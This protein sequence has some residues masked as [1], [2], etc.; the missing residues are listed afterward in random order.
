MKT[1]PERLLTAASC[2]E[3]GSVIADVGCDHG[4]LPH[5]LL[6][7]GISV[8]AYLIDKNRGPLLRA[9]QNTE[10]Y[11]LSDSCAHVVSDG[12]KELNTF[13]SDNNV[14]AGIPDTVIMTG[15]GGPLILKIIDE[16]PEEIKRNVSTF[17]LSPQSL[18]EDCKEGL[19]ERG[20]M[21]RDEKM[22]SDKGKHY[23]IIKGE[24]N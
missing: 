13:I 7:K 21:I 10:K 15:M 4:L 22:V 11:G 8:F 9:A 23:T 20:F 14:P 17:I 16:A 3:K 18:I 6:K 5:Y 1:L 12:L 19:R 24:I 2:G